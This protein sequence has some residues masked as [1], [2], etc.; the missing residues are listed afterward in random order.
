VEKRKLTVSKK[1]M[2]APMLPMNQ[3]FA[4]NGRSAIRAATAISIAPIRLER[5][6][7]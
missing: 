4:E 6:E 5:P 2:T 7:R 1:V 3:S